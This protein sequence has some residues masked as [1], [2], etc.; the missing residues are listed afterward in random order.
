MENYRA[1]D[2][3]ETML[4]VWF[5]DLSYNYNTIERWKFIGEIPLGSKSQLIVINVHIVM[6]NQCLYVSTTGV[7]ANI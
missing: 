2:I 6:E 1:S 4:T 3:S 7:Q 5:L